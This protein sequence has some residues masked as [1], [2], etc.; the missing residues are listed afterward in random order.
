[1]SG[2]CCISSAPVSD[3]ECVYSGPFLIFPSYSVIG[4]DR[5]LLFV[6]QPLHGPLTNPLGMNTHGVV[7]CFCVLHICFYKSQS[8]NRLLFAKHTLPPGGL[9]A[10]WV[11]CTP[12]S[13]PT[14]FSQGPPFTQAPLPA[15]TVTVAASEHCLCDLGENVSGATEREST[16]ALLPSGHKC[17]HVTISCT[18]GIS[19]HQ[20]EGHKKGER[21]CP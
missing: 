11:S 17:P 21:A 15:I 20:W 5:C 16:A 6:N 12:H 19:R 9:P 10:K 4:G 18:S 1:M 7:I 8:C 2:T 14:S 3:D 13:T